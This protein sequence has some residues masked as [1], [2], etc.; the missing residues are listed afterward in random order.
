M[1]VW[2]LYRYSSQSIPSLKVLTSRIRQ[3]IRVCKEK[4][5]KSLHFMSPSFTPAAD[6]SRMQLFAVAMVTNDDQYRKKKKNKARTPYGPF[7]RPPQGKQQRHGKPS[8]TTAKC[9]WNV[10]TRLPISF[11][12]GYDDITPQKNAL[13]KDGLSL[14]LPSGYLCID[15]LLNKRFYFRWNTESTVEKSRLLAM[16]HY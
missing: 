13:H 15:S 2:E 8:L 16:E 1:D 9:G 10:N 14:A 7:N 4:E 6:D 5:G 12:V 3:K 11:G